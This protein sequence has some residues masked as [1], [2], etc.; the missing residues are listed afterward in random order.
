MFA[1]K[2][3]SLPFLDMGTLFWDK[4]RGKWEDFFG[5]REYNRI[6][7]LNLSGKRKT[8]VARELQSTL[9]ILSNSLKSSGM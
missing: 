7:K 1:I 9:N 2:L 6:K 5:R 8:V 4:Q 3:K